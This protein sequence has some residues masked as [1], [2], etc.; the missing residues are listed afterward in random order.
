MKNN[1]K[2]NEKEKK[3]STTDI[4]CELTYESILSAEISTLFSFQLKK[5]NECNDLNY[6]GNTNNKHVL[7]FTQIDYDK[8]SLGSGSA[9]LNRV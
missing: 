6:R 3:T 7:A 2:H 9:Y 8:N 1:E 4:F 5:Y